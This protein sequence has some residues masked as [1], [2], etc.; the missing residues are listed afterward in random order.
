LLYNTELAKALLN[1]IF[2]Y[3]ECGRWTKPFPAHDIGTYPIANGQTY[4][5]DMPV[6]ESGNMLTLTAAIAII[7]GNAQYAEKHWK[8]LTTWA[9]YLAEK[10]FDP[11]NQLS[12]DDFAGHLAHN[13]NLSIKAILGIASYGQLAKMLGKEDIAD[14]YITLAREMAIEWMELADDG[15]HYR[16]TFDR[17]GTWSQKYNLIWDKVLKLNIFPDIVAT[18]EIHYYLTLQNKYGLPLDSRK[19]FTKPDWIMWTAS[20]APDDTIFEQFIGPLHLFMKE[21]ATRA[22]MTDLFWTDKPYQYGMQ[23]RSVVGGFFMKMLIE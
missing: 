14:K 19:N 1:H 6:E 7:E 5:H 21:S 12:T 9:E 22:P 16:L 3:S 10:G 23:A 8:V 20:L 17:P 4:P 18:K 13:T 2:F 15:D 11:E